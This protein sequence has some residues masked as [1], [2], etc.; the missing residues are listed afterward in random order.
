MDNVTV[1]K[2]WWIK[3]KSP[4]LPGMQLVDIY[5]EAEK[6]NVVQCLDRN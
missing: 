1:R 6:G 3:V 4:L 2:R 5:S